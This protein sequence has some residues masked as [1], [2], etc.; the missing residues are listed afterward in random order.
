MALV[1]LLLGKNVKKG[2]VKPEDSGDTEDIALELDATMVESP[3]YNATPTMNEVESGASITDHVTLSPETLTI[4]GI[5][6]NT[7]IGI[8]QLLSGAQFGNPAQDA[9]LFLK[10]LYDDRLPFDFVGG[11][12]V[13]SSMVITGFSP[14]RTSTTGQ[15][16]RFRMTMQQIRIV[17]SE[18]VESRRFSDDTKHTAQKSQ[19]L[20]SQATDEASEKATERGS[21]ILAKW[22]PDLLR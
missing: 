18:V 3:E 7:P 1:Q 11:L 2:F 5:V 17:E 14:S 20:G 16:L 4:E 15:A 19:D 12:K 13:Y 22:F 8:K 21:S 10:K 9:F 6:T